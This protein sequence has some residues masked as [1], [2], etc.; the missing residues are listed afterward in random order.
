MNQI[1]EVQVVPIKPQEGLVGFAS[2]VFNQSIFLGG[3]LRVSMTISILP[4]GLKLL[5]WML[6]LVSCRM[7]KIST[8]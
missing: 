1:T 7:Q 3:L 4:L 2:F 6:D 8:I 5:K